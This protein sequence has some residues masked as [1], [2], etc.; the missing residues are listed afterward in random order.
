[1]PLLVTEM[2]KMKFI[3]KTSDFPISAL[4]KWILSVCF[5]IH[6]LK[7]EVQS[8]MPNTF[9]NEIAPLKKLKK[10]KVKADKASALKEVTL[11]SSRITT[12]LLTSS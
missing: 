7:L 6:T 8:E 5:N 12:T 2:I 9:H 1:M 10:M 11:I 4:I 3:L